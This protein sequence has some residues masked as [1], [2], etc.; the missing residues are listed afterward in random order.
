MQ[1]P[2][3]KPGACETETISTLSLLSSLTRSKLLRTCD[4]KFLLGVLSPESSGAKLNQISDARSLVKR[5][6]TFSFVT[7]KVSFAKQV[8]NAFLPLSAQK[9]W[10]K[11][12]KTFK[13]YSRMLLSY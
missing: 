3:L 2:Q 9:S 5:S 10:E 4:L 11:C 6:C 1:L 7:C 8:Q 13:N 12:Q